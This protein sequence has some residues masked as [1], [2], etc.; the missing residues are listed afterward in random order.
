MRH[1]IVVVLIAYL[2]TG[3][4]WVWRDLREPVGRQPAYARSRKLPVLIL[5]VLTWLPASLAMPA[6]YGWYWK[7]LKRHVFS[8][9]LF[10]VLVCVGLWL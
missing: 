4:H 10:A 7:S 5:A 8:L 2:I 3:V 1:A 9:F 6:A